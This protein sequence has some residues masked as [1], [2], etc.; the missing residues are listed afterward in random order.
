[1]SAGWPDLRLAAPAVACWLSALG[2]LYLSAFWGAALAGLAAGAAAAAAAW[3][4]RSAG[5]PGGWLL[6]GVLLGVVCGAASTAAR[7]AGRDAE[8]LAGL[9]RDRATVTA[10]LVVTDDPRPLRGTTGR[11]PTYA[12]AAELTRLRHDSDSVRLSAR[13]LVLAGDRAWRTL[14]PGQRVIA[15][16]RLGPPRPG[17]L[18]A[19][20]LSVAHAPIEVGAPRWEQRA[21]ERLRAGL[22]HAC[23]PLPV[24]A[25]G[26]LPGL[27]VGDT[28]HLEPAV[29]DDFV[30]TG[31]THLV[32]V[33][34]SNVAIVIGAVLLVTRWCRAGPRLAAA[35]CTLALVG[36]VIL[37]RPSPSVL[38]AAAMGALGL[39]ALASGRPR[40]AV[41]ALAATVAVLVMVDPQ[42]AVDA[43]FALSV[44]ATAGL[45]ILAPGWRDA[46]RER[47]VPAGLAEALAI[48]AAAQV[49]C[50]PVIAAISGTVG[51]AAIP[52]NMLAVPAVAP[53]TVIGVAAA[54]LSVCWPAGAEWAAWLASWPA[55]WL[56]MVARYGAE[57][58]AGVAAWPAGAAGGLLLAALLGA[59]VLGARRPV[60]RRLVLVAALAAVLGVLPV[61]VVA[62]GWPPLDWLVVA[63]DVGQG[64]AVVIPVGPG[65]AAVVDAGPDPAAIDRCL[66]R[67][68]VRHVGLLMITHFHADHVAG[69]AGVFRGRSV[70]E[71]VMT[72]YPEPAA[73][74]EAVLSMAASEQ[75]PTRVA[76]AGSV[77]RLGAVRLAVLGPVRALTGTRSDPNNNS[78]VVLAETR[79]RRILLAGDAEEDEQRVVLDAAGRSALHA[80]VL[81][82]A[83]HGSA[84]QDPEFLDAVGPAV[85]LVSVGA[86]N[87]YGHPNPA[88]LA[89]LARAGARVLRTDV[90]ADVA[91]VLT[92]GGLAVVV[93]GHE[94][95]RHPP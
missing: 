81:K 59:A 94:P 39:V 67:L 70:A 62:S 19:A 44:L 53:A 17:D 9:A 5:I 61:R 68:G 58:P 86:G 45:L 26:L 7:V 52:A 69:I 43:G 82:V 4:R 48:P 37:V 33:S 40:A 93:R 54:L 85:A 16:G 21:A 77:Y 49:A 83:H 95:G 3:H 14:L 35:L 84:Y 47:G 15:V 13:V 72:A 78:L 71:I 66:R 2:A 89:R 8:P 22:R 29:A 31:M 88:V 24:D 12:V 34:G 41:P 6:V 90:D 79:G 65:Q 20:V 50:A 28:S 23:A 1:M 10:D 87:P 25:G 30:T 56:V 73:G 60:V 57:A 74:R 92:P 46:L 63:C 38:R 76:P 42:L 27:V 51:L 36:F 18:R 11:P 64:D 75:V 80:D 55:H 32:A 91:A